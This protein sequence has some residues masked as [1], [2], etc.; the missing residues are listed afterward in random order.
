MATETDH[1]Q[2]SKQ[3]QQNQTTIN[4]ANNGNRNR[5][6]PTQQTM[7][8]ETD[9]KQLSKQW[10]RKQTTTNSANNGNRNRPQPTQQT[11]PTE[12][13]HNQL[14]KNWQ[15]FVLTSQQHCQHGTHIF[16]TPSPKSTLK[17]L[18]IVTHTH[19]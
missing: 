2:L 19:L 1:N 12:T 8:T 9:H 6:Q 5:P 15:D 13:D 17:I 4:S 3:W 11:M 16:L 10:Q 18:T 14:S 7:A